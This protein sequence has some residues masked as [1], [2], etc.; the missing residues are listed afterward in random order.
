LG[1]F[2]HS[3]KP[4]NCVKFV[5]ADIGVTE[6]IPNLQIHDSV[7]PYTVSAAP[8]QDCVALT[9]TT[10]M[11]SLTE[12]AHQSQMGIDLCRIRLG[13]NDAPWLKQVSHFT[14]E[15]PELDCATAHCGCQNIPPARDR[16]TT[17]LI[18]AQSPEDLACLVP[19]R[20]G[21]V[22]ASK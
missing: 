10:H 20:T 11:L 6:T 15:W 8:R 5:L 2:N 12:I 13:N 18:C 17:D 22:A 19:G 7:Q 3:K 16:G 9:L 1:N 14:V 4:D 21:A